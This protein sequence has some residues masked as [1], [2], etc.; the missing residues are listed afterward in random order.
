M[1]DREKLA[2]LR[3]I[4]ITLNSLSGAVETLASERKALIEDL[5]NRYSFRYLAQELGV[6]E[7]RLWQIAHRGE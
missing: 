7:T 3:A 1:T 4:T 6:S 2:R 5:H